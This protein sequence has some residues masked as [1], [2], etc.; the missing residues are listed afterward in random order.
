MH[1]KYVKSITKLDVKSIRAIIPNGPSVV[2]MDA[3]LARMIQT[4]K[5][6]GDPNNPR[7]G[8]SLLKQLENIKT[9]SLC[10]MW[11]IHYSKYQLAVVCECCRIVTGRIK[12][13]HRCSLCRLIICQHCAI[14]LKPMIMVESIPFCLN[15]FRHTMTK[16]Y[17][18]K[19]INNPVKKVEY[20][21]SLHNLPVELWQTVI[22]F[23]FDEWESNGSINLATSFS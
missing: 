16:K 5:L 12:N 10:D 9:S 2:K 3:E 4:Y 23:L 17:L 14:F 6:I 21:N 13:A 18:N 1:K 8:R 7:D 15:C 11:C 20:L 19:Q 22:H